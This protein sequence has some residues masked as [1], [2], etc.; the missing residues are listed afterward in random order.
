MKLKKRI[1]ISAM[2]AVLAAAML[3]GCGGAPAKPSTST[4]G[5]HAGTGGG[6]SSSSS[7]TSS[8]TSTGDKKDDNTT[9]PKEDGN[10]T[11]KPTV[12]TSRMSKYYTYKENWNQYAYKIRFVGKQNNEVTITTTEIITDGN[13]VAYREWEGEGAQEKQISNSIGDEKKQE[14][15]SISLETQIVYQYPFKSNVSGVK[16]A[17][18]ANMFEDLRKFDYPMIVGTREVDGKWYYTETFVDEV[19]QSQKTFCFEKGDTEGRHLKYILYETTAG[20][21][22]EVGRVVILEDTQQVNQAELRIPEGWPLVDYP[23]MKQIGTTPKD[24][25]PN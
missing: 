18:N 22:K 3:A 10:K 14:A 6:S 13:R 7:S 9:P 20:T 16:M 11:D 15:F 5:N 17:E 8:S 24:N 2:A 23:T 21:K 19:G 25:Y 4:G 12:K 1:A